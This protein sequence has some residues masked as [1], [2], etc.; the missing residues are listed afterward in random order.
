MWNSL[1]TLK[2][3]HGHRQSYHLKAVVWFLISNFNFC[4]RIVYKFRNIG[5]VN[6]K[7]GLNEVQIQMKFKVIERGT[8]RK[9]VYGW[10]TVTFAVSLTVS[11]I[12]DVNFYAENRVFTYRT[13]IWLWIWMSCRWNV[14]TKFGA[15]KLESRCCH[16]VKKLWSQVEPCG[17][18]PPVQKQA[19]GRTDGLT[20]R[21]TDLR[22]L[23]ALCIASRGKNRSNMWCM[24][25]WQKSC[26]AAYLLDSTVY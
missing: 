20:D 25:L 3:R 26:T 24:Q 19:D 4:E 17:H 10:S 14:E 15:R 6:D 5:G 18:S 11:E 1:T 21:W 12:Q 13:C 16:M 23:T 22:W 7:M 9:V 2:Y 8:N